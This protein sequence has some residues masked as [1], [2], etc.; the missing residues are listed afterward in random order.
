MKPRIRRPI[1]L[2]LLLSST[3]SCLF[4][5]Q[6]R[7]VGHCDT[8]L[9][10]EPAIP[11]V[12]QII[13]NNEEGK[14]VG[15]SLQSTFVHCWDQPGAYLVLRYEGASDEAFTERIVVQ[16]QPEVVVD[17]LASKGLAPSNDCQP[18]IRRIE[19][20]ACSGSY[21]RHGRQ[22]LAAGSEQQ[23][24]YKNKAGCDSIIQVHVHS[25]PPLSFTVRT[26]TV[27]WNTKEGFIDIIN[28]K[29]GVP[30]YRFSMDRRHY[31]KNPFF[32]QLE[33]GVY[34]IYI[35]DSQGCLDSSV[36]VIPM[37][38]PLRYRVEDRILQCDQDSVD[39]E[40]ELFS[41]HK[42]IEYKWPNGSTLP[43]MKVGKPDIYWVT[44]S[45]ECESNF[46]EVL[47]GLGEQQDPSYLYLPNAF[48]PNSDGYN[49][50]YRAYAASGAEVIQ[51]ELSIFDRSG[52][53]V[54]FTKD[55]TYGW[56]GAH[57]DQN[58]DGGVYMWFVRA[59]VVY[60]YREIEI[61]REGPV[62][63]IR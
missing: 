19:Y 4:G 30:P 50:Q 55:I 53:R 37:I 43:Y 61:T 41:K 60:C 12:W 29:G 9:F 32:D 51:Y 39:L 28:P 2:L 45:N 52:T 5:Q 63:L 44:I 31:K 36:V 62:T 34:T 14:V 25:L 16:P 40:V 47:V 8:F 49:D 18:S 56:D 35:K 57:L 26:D 46:K 6:E 13:Q 22:S 11:V 17:E 24:V 20:T 7:L 42:E 59:I 10:D 48:S 21:I 3:F 54:F 58:V 27:C 38:E 15:E 23:F 1:L 33:G